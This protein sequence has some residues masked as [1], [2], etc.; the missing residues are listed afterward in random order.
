M[1]WSYCIECPLALAAALVVL[2]PMPVA[3]AIIN[4]HISD[5][6]INQYWRPDMRVGDDFYNDPSRSD[7]THNQVF[8]DL[9]KVVREVLGDRAKSQILIPMP[10]DS[11]ISSGADLESQI[12]NDLKRTIS[13]AI[14]NGNYDY[15]FQLVQH[16]NTQGYF[17]GD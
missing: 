6:G 8:G 1:R 17:D 2:F 11:V 4:I 16:I 15:E 12:Y 14:G 13:E 10:D 5:F 7:R 3:A 9:H